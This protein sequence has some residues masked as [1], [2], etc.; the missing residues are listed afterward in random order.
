MESLQNLLHR[1]VLKAKVPMTEK[2]QNIS[3]E[4]NLNMCSDNTGMCS[5][6]YLKDRNVEKY[7]VDSSNDRCLENI[8]NVS[9]DCSLGGSL[10]KEYLVQNSSERE[11]MSRT[12]DY[13]ENVPTNFDSLNIIQ[14]NGETLEKVETLPSIGMTLEKVETL[15]SIGMTKLTVTSNDV[16][17]K[18]GTE[19]TEQLPK[20]DGAKTCSDAIKLQTNSVVQHGVDHA[21]VPVNPCEDFILNASTAKQN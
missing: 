8:K 17:V 5:E 14:R 7:S 1:I 6:K 18:S 4:E 10:E 13:K 16:N 20:S 9:K 2:V 15:P 12:G 3:E 21:N 19:M 11:S